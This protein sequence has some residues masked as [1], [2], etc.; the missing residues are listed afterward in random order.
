MIHPHTEVRYI[1]KDIGYGVFATRPIPKGTLIWTLCR[2]DRILTQQES[3][4]LPKPYRDLLVHYAFTDMYGNLVLCWDGGRYVNHSCDPAML[5]VDY[6]FEIAV[7][8]IAAGEEV[9]CDYGNL[10]LNGSLRCHCGAPG[11][12]S[13]ISRRDAGMLWR[14]W[15]R[16]VADALTLAS[17]L[18][19]P[20][21]DYALEPQV[22]RDYAKGVAA[23]PS[24]GSC[25]SRRGWRPPGCGPGS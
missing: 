18:P 5:P 16:S 8:D 21:L 13:E 23:A 6:G 25:A 9:T 24:H 4:D 17:R 1:G 20:L 12:R 10:N 11:C 7:R 3:R 19:Q 14:D 2:F 22:F 15:D